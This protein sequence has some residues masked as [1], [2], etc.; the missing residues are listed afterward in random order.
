MPGVPDEL[1]QQMTERDEA[2]GDGLTGPDYECAEDRHLL[3]A[4]VR[5]LRAIVA[6]TD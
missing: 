3:L 1:M 6:R 2:T 5:R 4:E